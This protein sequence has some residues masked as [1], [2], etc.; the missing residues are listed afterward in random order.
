MG[1]FNGRLDYH[2]Q[3]LRLNVDLMN[4]IQLGITLYNEDGETPPAYPD[5]LSAAAYSND[6]SPCPM[7][8]QFNFRFVQDAD[9]HNPE[10]ITFLLQHGMDIERHEHQGVD[11]QAFA[12]LLVS[13]GMVFLDEVKWISFH[14]GYDFAYLVKV[15]YGK[16]FPEV[17]SE[18]RKLLQLMFPSIFDIKYMLKI[19]QKTQ[20]VN[21][22]PLSASAL[23]FFAALGAKA[24]L[25]DLAD[26]LGIKR[27]GQAHQ[28][29][30][31]SLITGRVFWEFKK[32]VMGGQLEEE[33]FL[34]RMWGLDAMGL[35]A[36]GLED[37]QSTPNLNGA[38]IYNNGAPSTPSTTH[39]G[40]AQTPN[41]QGNL[42]GGVGALTPGGGGGVFGRFGFK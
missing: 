14:S 22:G 24:G 9:M 2:Y 5:F 7:T 10:S 17:E 8:W 31:D 37:N 35:G 19:I 3:T 38:T 6:G 13:S 25:Q 15:V 42:N 41:Q 32:A 28:A 23:N 33:R 21:G 40:L 26:E 27:V 11:F 29:G 20:M 1:R 34:N 16:Q 12:S 36:P 39:T 4:I 30:S 18:Y